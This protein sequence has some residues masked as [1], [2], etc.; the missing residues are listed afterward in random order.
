M[1][2]LLNPLDGF[3]VGMPIGFTGVGGGALMTPVLV[4]LFG[5]APQIAVETDL[6]FASITKAVG[7]WVHGKR[8]VAAIARPVTR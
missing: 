1:I 7:G 5:I 4:F 3:L 2:D 8:A 6:P